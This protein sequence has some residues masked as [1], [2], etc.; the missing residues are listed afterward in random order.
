MEHMPMI[1]MNMIPNRIYGRR[2][3]IFRMMEGICRQ[4]S[5]SME[6]DM[7]AWDSIIVLFA[8]MTYGSMIRIPTN[9]PGKQISRGWA[10]TEPVRL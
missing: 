10:D 1:F 3:P 7:Y 8:G 5:P 4:L 6:K 2:K 9:G